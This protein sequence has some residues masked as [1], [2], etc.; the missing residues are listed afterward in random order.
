MKRLRILT[1]NHHTSYLYLLAK[2]GHRFYVLNG[3]DESQRPIPKNCELVSWKEAIDQFGSFDVVIGHHITKDVRRLL[4]SCLRWKKPYI[5]VIHGRKGRTGYTKSYTR[6]W[7]KSIYAALIL[8]VLEKISLVKYVFISEYD[9]SDW[10]MNGKV[11]N[12]GIPVDEM[13]NYQGDKAS[14][15]VVGNALTREH[16]D[17]QTLLKLKEKLPIKIVGISQGLAESQPARDWDEL[18]TYYSEY[19]AFLNLTKEPEKGYNLAT[20]EAMATGMPVISLWHPFT[21]IKDGWNGFLV[22]SFEEMMEKCMLLLSDLKLA[23]RLGKNAKQ[24]V[25]DRYHIDQFIEKWNAVLWDV[26]LRKT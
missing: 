15:L 8:R 20:L 18:R 14:L 26:S 17:F 3:W 13:Y 23:I 21:P 12:H 19:R 22:Q 5:Q 7:T 11:I 25:I 9:K 10:P 16:F 24:T 6:K 4:P 2:T 1:V